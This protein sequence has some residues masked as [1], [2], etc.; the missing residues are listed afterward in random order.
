MYILIHI[1]M[2]MDQR[3][4]YTLHKS[5]SNLGR[6]TGLQRGAPRSGCKL[7]RG[8]GRERRERKEARTR[9]SADF[10][11]RGA[12]SPGGW[13][14]KGADRMEWGGGQGAPRQ[15]DSTTVRVYI[16]YIKYIQINKIH[17]S[18]NYQI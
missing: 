2:Y 16:R 7:T 1:Y 6:F 11:A 9:C 18:K 15:Y 4:P 8:K 17:K 3:R 12:K 10:N 5:S 13:E 14:R